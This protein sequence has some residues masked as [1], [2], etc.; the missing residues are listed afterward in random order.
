[1]A[2]AKITPHHSFVF[3]TPYDAAN[4]TAEGV[5]HLSSTKAASRI[6][7]T[8]TSAQFNAVGH[9]ASAC[10]LESAKRKHA[11]EAGGKLKL[12][13]AACFQT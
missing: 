1:M 4:Y 12:E 13:S 10:H 5:L 8:P 11:K 6:G 2:Q 3:Y 7:L 9:S